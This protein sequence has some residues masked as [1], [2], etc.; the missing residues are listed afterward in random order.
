MVLSSKPPSGYMK[1]IFQSLQI[2]PDWSYRIR[3]HGTHHWTLATKTSQNNVCVMCWRFWS[4][5]FLQSRWYSRYWNFQINLYNC[6]QLGWRPTAASDS[7]RNMMKGKL[8][9]LCLDMSTEYWKHQLSCTH[10][11]STYP[12]PLDR[13]CVCI[14][15]TSVIN[16]IFRC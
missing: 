11:E 9:Y 3:T 8:T 1:T 10:Q 15:Q 6:H 13:T 5:V 2:I 7:S 16:W 14:L 12:S 4:Q